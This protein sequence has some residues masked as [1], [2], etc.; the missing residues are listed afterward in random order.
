MFLPGMETKQIF[1]DTWSRFG[2]SEVS[3]SLSSLEI[4]ESKII[5]GWDR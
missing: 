3:D 4:G 2:M 5:L 1:E